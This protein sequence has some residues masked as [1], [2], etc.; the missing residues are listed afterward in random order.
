MCGIGGNTIEEAQCNISYEEFHSWVEYRNKRGSLNM[1]M[2]VEHASALLAQI[3]ANRYRK[4]NA[5]AFSI[6]D[7]APHHDE[8]ELTLEDMKKW[9]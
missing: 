4:E 7:F 6:Y 1:G 3:T 9:Q 2:R 8:P 5:P